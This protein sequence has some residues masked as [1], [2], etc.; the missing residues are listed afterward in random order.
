MYHFNIPNLEET[1]AIK[2]CAYKINLDAQYK[3]R[4]IAFTRKRRRLRES[5]VFVKTYVW[6]TN[7]WRLNRCAHASCSSRKRKGFP[8]VMI[9]FLYMFMIIAQSSSN[10][11]YCRWNTGIHGTAR[12]AYNTLILSKISK[13]STTNVRPQVM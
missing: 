6:L 2:I 11:E 9:E 3:P 12:K 8:K 10:K 4:K 7:Q 13:I 5:V 1:I